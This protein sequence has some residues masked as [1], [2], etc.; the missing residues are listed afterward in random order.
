MPDDLNALRHIEGFPIGED[1]DIFANRR[2]Q[3]WPA[4]QP[5]VS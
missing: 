5:R 1:A 4:A 2:E 3:S